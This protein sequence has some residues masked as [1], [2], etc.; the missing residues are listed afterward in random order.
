MGT[1]DGHRKSYYKNR[2]KSRKRDGYVALV[3]GK[4]GHQMRQLSN[5]HKDFVKYYLETFNARR[6]AELAGF[7]KDTSHSLML[8]PLVRDEINIGITAL[9]EKKGITDDAIIKELRSVAFE[10]D[11]L[12]RGIRFADKIRALQLLGQELGMFEKKENMQSAV[13]PPSI[14][15][16]VDGDKPNDS[17]ISIDEIQP[18]KDAG[19]MVQ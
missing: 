18:N 11:P 6:A 19:G 14:T 15:I 8:N 12:S 9:F 1:P 7:N 5:R 10:K 17:E 13:Q 3:E 16:V 4:D 2:D